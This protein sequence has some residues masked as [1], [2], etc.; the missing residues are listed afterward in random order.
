MLRN[1]RPY[2]GGLR[3]G[4]RSERMLPD[5]PLSRGARSCDGNDAVPGWSMIGGVAGAR[6]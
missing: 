2:V 4:F 1:A 5:S 3:A 6:S